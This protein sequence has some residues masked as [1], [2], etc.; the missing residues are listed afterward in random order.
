MEFMSDVETLYNNQDL[1][2]PCHCRKQGFVKCRDIF[3]CKSLYTYIFIRNYYLFIYVC[4][5]HGVHRVRFVSDQLASP[6][7]KLV[8]YM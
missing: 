4:I 7:E 6:L 5:T 3:H 1:K 8:L 2:M